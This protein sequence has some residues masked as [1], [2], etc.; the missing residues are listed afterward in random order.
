MKHKGW[1][2]A[3]ETHTCSPW[4]RL[5]WL[6]EP[7]V[8]LPVLYCAGTVLLK[9]DLVA[10]TSDTHMLPLD[11]GA[12]SKVCITWPLHCMFFFSWHRAYHLC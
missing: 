2:T 6:H 8:V 4:T 5:W 7:H 1:N 9:N 3:H 10:G 11:K 12:L